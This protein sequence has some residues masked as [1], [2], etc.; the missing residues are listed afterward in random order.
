MI[1]SDHSLLEA[2]V[3][4]VNFK[5]TMKGKNGYLGTSNKFKLHAECPALQ[6]ADRELYNLL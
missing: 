4:V 3:F 1:I 5:R 6:D 2:H